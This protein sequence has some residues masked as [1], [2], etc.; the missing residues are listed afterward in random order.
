MRGR[1]AAHRGARRWPRL[2][3]LLLQAAHLAPVR[4][5]RHRIARGR[6]CARHCRLWRSSRPLRCAAHRASRRCQWPVA[7]EVRPLINRPG[8]LSRPN[9]RRPTRSRDGGMELTHSGVHEPTIC[10]GDGSSWPRQRV[11]SH[12]WGR[13]HVNGHPCIAAHRFCIREGLANRGRVPVCVSGGR[14]SF[15]RRNAHML[16]NISYLV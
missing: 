10:H 16:V 13:S 15:W 3:M 9:S 5:T 2:V 11:C 4:R 1:A 12:A 14:A 7:A 6:G 8:P